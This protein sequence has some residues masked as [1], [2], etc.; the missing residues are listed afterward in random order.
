MEEE[1]INTC[2]ISGYERNKQEQSKR[3]I[4]I[5]QKEQILVSRFKMFIIWACRRGLKIL[6]TLDIIGLQVSSATFYF[7]TSKY[8]YKWASKPYK[9]WT[10]AMRRTLFHYMTWLFLLYDGRFWSIF[11][12]TISL[13]PQL[14]PTYP[15][16]I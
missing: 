2:Q 3:K 6:H 15:S 1:A 16:V 7:L 14:C 10:T 4:V 8:S 11:P 5:R 13:Y 9:S 12:H